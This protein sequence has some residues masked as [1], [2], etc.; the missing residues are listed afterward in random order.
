MSSK[1][2]AGNSVPIDDAVRIISLYKNYWSLT[3]IHF[4]LG[5][6]RTTIRGVLSM[7]DY[8]I[9]KHN[10]V[11]AYKEILSEIGDEIISNYRK[12]KNL[13][14]A[15][16][17]LPIPPEVAINFIK[18]SGEFIE[19][20]SYSK[21]EEAECVRLYQEDY[22]PIQKIKEKIGG[23]SFYIRRVL[24]K[25]GINIRKHQDYKGGRLFSDTKGTAIIAEYL[26]NK[27]I[28]QLAKDYNSTITSISRL[29]RSRGYPIMKSQSEKNAF[30]NELS[31]VREYTEENL[32]INN[33]CEKYDTNLNNVKKILKRNKIKIKT[34]GDFNFIKLEESKITDFIQR[35]ESGKDS[36][37]S[38]ALSIN[39]CQSILKREFVLRGVR[40]RSR[41]YMNAV[42]DAEQGRIALE[43]Y[44]KNKTVKE[45]AILIGK[46]VFATRRFLNSKGIQ[47][48]R[49]FSASSRFSYQGVY[50]KIFFRSLMELSFIIDN[51]FSHKVESA[52]ESHKIKYRFDNKIRMYHPDFILDNNKI[53]EIK[54]KHLI[55]DRKVRRK[56]KAIKKFCIKNGLNFE[57]TD[58]P[59]NKNKIKNLF[60][61]GGFTLK[62]KTRESLEK[63][64]NINSNHYLF[65]I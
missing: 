55:E 22:L 1:F 60:L 37:E 54:P 42:L 57:I 5:Y 53:V 49:V 10:H 28:K 15:S 63:F 11:F 27:T 50:K 12:T 30:A 58:W 47:I 26:K 45:I 48:K 41:K 52:E 51:E 56:T 65:E 38:L 33:L 21:D 25:N 31:I 3:D 7:H 59:V 24:L 18:K 39:T 20:V 23:S 44:S 29:I 8:E 19:E 64:L 9:Q 4:Y 36:L 16:T 43:Q 32:T 2:I 62:N 46:S 17:N 6:D 34:A 40:I 13:K 35:Y 14:T 61:S